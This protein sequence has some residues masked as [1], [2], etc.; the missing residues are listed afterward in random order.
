MRD[1]VVLQYL[2]TTKVPNH[3]LGVTEAS[4]GA[5]ERGKQPRTVAG[6]ACLCKCAANVCDSGST[7]WD[8]GKSGESLPACS[9][10]SKLTFWG[11]WRYHIPVISSC[12]KKAG[13]RAIR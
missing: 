12:T 5:V 2:Q 3:L 1:K 6:S 4:P 7:G 9:F 13:G 10:F 11:G 8:G